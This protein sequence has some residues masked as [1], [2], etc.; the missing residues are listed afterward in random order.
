MTTET[1]AIEAASTELAHAMAR[2]VAAV[3]AIGDDGEA[4]RYIS[5]RMPEELER[6]AARLNAAQGLGT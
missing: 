3:D 2:L 4:S 5:K 1:D 6:L